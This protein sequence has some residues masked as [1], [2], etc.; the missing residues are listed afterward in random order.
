M[1]LISILALNKYY[2]EIFND[3][4]CPSTMNRDLIINTICIKNAELP[5]LY[6][7]PDTLQKLIEIWSKAHAPIWERLYNLAITDYNAIENYN[8]YESET[9]GGSGRRDG[10]GK[11]KNSVYGYN[12]NDKTPHDETENEYEENYNKTDSR[13]THTSGNIGVTTTQEMIKQ[14][15][16]IR[17][18]LNI[19]NFI[20]EEFK[21][22]FCIMVY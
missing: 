8:R 5:I 13:N 4:V 15:M 20:A 2:P 3:F 18:K 14:E 19:Y 22:E 7:A 21:Q 9:K 16:E 17:P 6:S 1:M 12:A 10:N 11:V